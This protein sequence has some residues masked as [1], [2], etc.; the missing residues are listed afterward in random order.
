MN[1]TVIIIMIICATV[2]ALV[3][4]ICN[5]RLERK[6]AE[7]NVNS[8]LSKKIIRLH[9]NYIAGI[10]GFAI[11]ML[12]TANYG[13]PNNALFEYISFGSTITS[14]VLSV[15]AIFVTV[16]SSSDLYKQ[17]TRI[18]NATDIVQ[19]VSEQIDGTLEVLE[20]TKSNLTETSE[21]ISLKLEN[22]V[23]QIDEKIKTRIKETE[24]SIAE[25]FTKSLNSIA[26][27][28]NQKL[29]EE[30]GVSVK[31]QSENDDKQYFL[32]IT[33]ATGLLGLYACALSLEKQKAFEI[34]Q[35]FEGF[36]DYSFG[37]LIAA[38]SA[39]YVNFTND[40]KNNLITCY[41]IQFTKE[42]LYG[43]IKQRIEQ[44][45][46]GVEYLNQVNIINDYFGE[47]SLVMKIE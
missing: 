11:I 13:S 34:S 32:N 40:E 35:L 1:T 42:E 12:I 15:L 4:I 25:R 29:L 2:I 22:I 33:S 8:T 39:K 31:L 9:R 26:Y 17:F 20:N 46:V 45:S 37:F 3:A 5:H 27:D 24:V 19:K 18:D 6:M 36:E 47:T 38:L 28:R 44:L 10:L 23:E 30:G 14:F 43:V 16:Q 41:S 21:Q 7:A